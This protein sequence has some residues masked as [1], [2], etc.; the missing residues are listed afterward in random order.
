[1]THVTDGKGLPEEL[2]FHNAVRYIV[3]IN[4][5][6]AMKLRQALLKKQA[7]LGKVITRKDLH[8]MMHEDNKNL[9]CSL[10]WVESLFKP[11]VKA[12][13]RAAAHAALEKTLGQKITF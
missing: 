12:K 3:T 11:S 10:A 2:Y 7:E 6:T 8:R 1:L 5:T 13:P 9:K 4:K